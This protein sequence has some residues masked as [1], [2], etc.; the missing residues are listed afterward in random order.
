MDWRNNQ[1]PKDT[2]LN[3]SQRSPYQDPAVRMVAIQIFRK[4]LVNDDMA[5]IARRGR[6]H[7]MQ[8]AITCAQRK[9]DVRGGIK[10]AS[11][12]RNDPDDVAAA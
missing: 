7:E 12:I 3:L 5:V 6:V 9:A 1:A 8:D 4:L 2:Q 10:P 11:V